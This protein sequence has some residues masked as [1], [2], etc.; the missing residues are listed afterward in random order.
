[1]VAAAG[2]TAGLTL[3]DR[4]VA[5]IA[6]IRAGQLVPRASFFQLHNIRLAHQDGDPQWLLQHELVLILQAASPAIAG[7]K[8]AN[9]ATPS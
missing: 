8:D 4:C 5:L 3:I 1:M 9:T 2:H 6:G 7:P